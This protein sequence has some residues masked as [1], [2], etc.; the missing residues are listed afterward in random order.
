MLF[1]QP[2]DVFLGVEVFRYGILCMHEVP[3]FPFGDVVSFVVRYYFIL[4]LLVNIQLKFVFTFD[5]EIFEILKLKLF[6]V[7]LGRRILEC[8]N[9][10]NDFFI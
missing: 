7:L 5:E 9:L 10:V 3:T 1:L 6:R 2:K 4:V 8:I